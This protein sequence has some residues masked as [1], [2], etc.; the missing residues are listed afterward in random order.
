MC[1][2]EQQRS[3]GKE[4]QVSKREDK[5]GDQLT[6][7]LAGLTNSWRQTVQERQVELEEVY[8]DSSEQARP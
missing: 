8:T 2:W 3:S 7:L 1:V 4:K 5:S 6:W